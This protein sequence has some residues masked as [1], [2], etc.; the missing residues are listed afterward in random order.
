LLK[1]SFIV[2]PIFKLILVLPIIHSGNNLDIHNDI[3]MH[4]LD[5]MFYSWM[6]RD[7]NLTYMHSPFHL[8]P[9]HEKQLLENMLFNHTV[10][11]WLVKWIMNYINRHTYLWVLVRVN[12]NITTKVSSY[13]D[14]SEIIMNDS[15]HDVFINKDIVFI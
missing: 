10:T 1:K 5:S 13:A 2:L 12:A 14:T 8:A 15:Q 4:P 11:I 3:S 7:L 6:E 9:H